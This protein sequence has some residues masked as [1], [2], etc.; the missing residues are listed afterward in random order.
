ML[1]LIQLI[2][3]FFL[4]NISAT[5][6]EKLFHNRDHSD[7]QTL[8][9]HKAQAITDKYTAE[10]YCFFFFFFDFLCFSNVSI[11]LTRHRICLM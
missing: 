6:A 8:N 11:H 7:T 5:D 9:S 10:V 4:T 2:F 1:N 3:M